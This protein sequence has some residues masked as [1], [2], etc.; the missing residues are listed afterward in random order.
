MVQK[1]T[2]FFALLFIISFGVFVYLGRSLE[3]GG[4][5]S[6]IPEVLK[7]KTLEKYS[8]T[9]LRSRGYLGSQ[10]VVG[11]VIKN[12]KDFVSQEFYFL[13]D[14]KKVAGLINF[15]LT[16]S[17][18]KL[19]VIV[20]FRGY[21]DK[22]GYK[23][24]GGTRHVAE[25][26][27]SRGF[28]TLAPDF[29]GYGAS[30]AADSDPLRSRFETYITAANLLNSLASLPQVDDDHV[31]IWGHSNGGQIALTALEITGLDYPTALWAPVSKPFPFSILFYSDEASDSGKA[32]RGVV[33]GFD[34][35][36]D[37][38]QYS[39]TSF[40]GWVVAPIQLQQG[41]ADDIVL[42]RWSRELSKNLKGLGKEVRYLEYAGANHNF[43][44]EIWNK[45]VSDDVAFY[46]S[47]LDDASL[48]KL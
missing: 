43:A 24:G 29:L 9:N 10:I 7:E 28:I 11:N 18:H 44:G 36:Y 8:Y 20:L 3:W 45:A 21:M 15:P 42:P 22:E 39:L 16:P 1:Y 14:G 27:A 6:K 31:F 19:P 35:D 48:R 13:S 2:I 12:G 38:N 5:R 46:N 40:L 47:F 30:D 23:A 33:A 4:S 37:A 26:F 25:Y 34:K 41:M 32:L 17:S